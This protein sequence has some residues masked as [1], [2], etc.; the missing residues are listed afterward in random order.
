M[1]LSQNSIISFRYNMS[2]GIEAQECE[3]HILYIGTIYSSIQFY[4][5]NMRMSDVFANS[6]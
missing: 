5:S 2:N 3:M 6:I 1:V 4:I